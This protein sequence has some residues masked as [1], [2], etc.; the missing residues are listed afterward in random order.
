MGQNQFSKK[1]IKQRLKVP[2]NEAGKKGSLISNG[3]GKFSLP[4]I[5]D[6]FKRGFYENDL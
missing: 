3:S 6:D 2:R 5:E 4:R 1:V